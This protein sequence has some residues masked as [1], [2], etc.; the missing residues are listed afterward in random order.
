VSLTAGRDPATLTLLR[1]GALDSL[2]E[3]ASWRRAGHACFA[4]I[5]LG[6][7]AGLPEQQVNELAWNGPVAT[8]IEAAVR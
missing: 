4:R 3:M 1:T 5:L 7:I 6:R 8:I 2:I